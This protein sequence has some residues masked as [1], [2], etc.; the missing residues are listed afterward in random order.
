MRNTTTAAVY[1]DEIDYDY[2][3]FYTEHMYLQYNLRKN[4]IIIQL[5]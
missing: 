4:K 1:A 2:D 5:V 3:Y